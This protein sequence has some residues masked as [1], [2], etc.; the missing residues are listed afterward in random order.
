MPAEGALGVAS[1][2]KDAAIA[3]ELDGVD[4]LA[5]K[6]IAACIR[7]VAE[8]VHAHAAAITEDQMVDIAALGPVAVVG[9]ATDGAIPRV[10][11]ELAWSPPVHHDALSAAA[12]LP[13]HG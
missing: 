3:E 10:L 13:P 2:L 5:P 1:A 7:A 11:L 9:H 6:H 4:A 12:R 8:H